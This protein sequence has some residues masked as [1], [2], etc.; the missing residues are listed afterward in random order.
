M[1]HPRVDVIIL[2]VIIDR[3]A[4]LEVEALV[5]FCQGGLAVVNNKILQGPVDEV[6][7]SKPIAS[8]PLEDLAVSNLAPNT[9]TCQRTARYRISSLNTHGDVISL[10]L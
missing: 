5:V 2:C 8:L 9:E 3:I 10:L 6:R 4:K 1:L 7:V